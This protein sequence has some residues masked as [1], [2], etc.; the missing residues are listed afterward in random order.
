MNNSTLNLF[1][2]KALT[3]I[4]LYVL[5]YSASKHVPFLEIGY[6]HGKPDNLE[7]IASVGPYMA[8]IGR[9]HTQVWQGTNPLEVET[10]KWKAT[11]EG[12]IAHGNLLLPLAN[13]VFFISPQ[14]LYG[15]PWPAIFCCRANAFTWSKASG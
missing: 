3:I 12:G 11:L 13:D 5:R 7:A 2:L 9:S 14:G 10:F 15:L 6:K 4:N 1:T 8:F